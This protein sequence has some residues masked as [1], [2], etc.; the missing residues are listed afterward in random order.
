MIIF[1]E[2]CLEYIFPGHPESPDRVRVVYEYLAKKRYKF[3]EAK[4]CQKEDILLVHTSSHFERVKNNNFFDPDTPN[5]ENIHTYAMLSAGGAIQAA[6]KALSGENSFSLLRPPGHHAGRNYLGGFC[7]F[8]NIAIAT[9][10]ALGKVDKVAIVDFDGHHGN[11]TEDIFR[12][13]RRVLY[14]S[15]HQSPAYPGTGLRSKGNALNFPLSPGCEEPEFMRFFLEGIEKI[16]KFSPSLI[17][18][19]AG[20]DAHRSESLLSLN[21]ETETY[22]KIGKGIATLNKPVFA[23]LEGGY[24]EKMPFCVDNFLRGLGIR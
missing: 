13:E 18:I 24:H 7:Y 6:K 23:V 17:A 19:S 12:G 3:E 14:F 2:K 15:L 9:T 1:S 8:N 4:S 11:G 22:F 21:L 20:F 16:R 10:W 5:L